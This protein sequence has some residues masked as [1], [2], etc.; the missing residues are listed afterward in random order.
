M[1]S[2]V[3]KL[4]EDCWSK[5]KKVLV[6][7]KNF[8]IGEIKESHEILRLNDTGVLYNKEDGI[9]KFSPSLDFIIKDSLNSF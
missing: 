7:N 5:L 2:L 6:S 1:S 4:S 9:I 3:L 8:A